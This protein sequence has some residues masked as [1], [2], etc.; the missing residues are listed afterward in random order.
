MRKDDS[1]PS[2]DPK[3]VPMRLACP[4]DSLRADAIVEPTAI[5]HPLVGD[6]PA[7]PSSG[8]VLN[9]RYVVECELGRGGMS[10]V[11]AARDIK[12]DRRVAIKFLAT[13]T[14]HDD[15]LRRFEQEARAAGSLNHPNVLTVYDIGT[16]EANPY[17][18]SELLE[19]G[20]LREHLEGAPFT[21]DES[22]DYAAQMADGLTAAHGKGIVHRDLKPENLFITGAGRLKILD[23]GI[24]KL[25]APERNSPELKSP[26]PTQTGAIL[27]TM[28]YMSPE[29][30]RGERADHRSDIFSGGAILYE[31][32]AGKRAFQASSSV[33]TAYAILHVKPPE[34]P[35]QVPTDL[36]SVVWRCLEKRPEDRFQSAR[37]LGLQLRKVSVAPSARRW[38]FAATAVVV[39]FIAFISVLS[40]GR[41]RGRSPPAA[42]NKARRSVAVLGFKNLSGRP[43]EA[44]FSTALSEMLS[45]ELA[46][47]E[48]LGTI[49]GESVSHMKTELALPDAETLAKETLFRIRKNLLADVVVLGS[50]V[51][52]GKEAGGQMRL[53]V[54]LQDAMA[55]ET[56]AV[57]SETGT[58]K[59][60]FEL[61]SRTGAKLRRKLGVGEVSSSEAAVVRAS[62]PSDVEA[63]RLYSEGLAKLRVFDANGA[64]DLLE[65]AVLVEPD[66]APSHSALSE[67]WSTLGYDA[68]ARDEAQKA[69][70]LSAALSRE[71]RLGVEG[72][73]RLTTGEWSKAIDV[74]KT[75]WDFFPDNVE[76]GVRLA[77]AQISAGKGKE[78][79]AT[80]EALSKLP[81][82]KGEDPRIDI[83][84]AEASESIS[85]F[86]REQE[87]AIRAVAKSELREAKLLAATARLRQ[88][89]A[90]LRLREPAKARAAYEE[91]QQIF[92]AAGNRADVARVSHN[93]GVLLLEQGDLVGA[94]ARFEQAL[95][96]FGD[97]GQKFLAA[98]ALVNIGGVLASEGDLEGAKRAHEQALAA[99]EKLG[100]KQGMA[101]SQASL[102]VVLLAEG[103]KT[104]AKR[105][106][107]ESLT[108]AREIGDR[109]AIS[110]ALLSLGTLLREEGDLAAARESYQQDLAIHREMGDQSGTAT[111][112]YNL[113]IILRDQGDLT[114]AHKSAEEA[115]AIK[116]QL[117]EEGNTA[118]CETSLASLALEEGRPSEAEALTRKAV[119]RFQRRQWPDG[120]AL[121]WAILAKSFLGQGEPD[122]AQ[123]AIARAAELAEKRR[124]P[125]LHFE[126]DIDSARVRA[127]MRNFAEAKKSLRETLAAAKK[128][129]SFR[130]H[131]EAR[132]ALGEIEMKSGH[133]G[134]A[135]AHLETVEKDATAHGFALIARRARAASK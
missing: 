22:I 30:V 84:E 100:D 93:I 27:G 42:A 66:H 23:F 9:E 76:Y 96:V 46:A 56:I 109:W 52:L 98:K 37:E 8:L 127:A 81:L 35:E 92:A 99:C 31:M 48:K 74:Y 62:L 88:G 53:D 61:V 77:R 108:T 73:Y 68:N 6:P 13:G 97:V 26:A 3:L 87:A 72:R 47:G 126:V 89:N 55:G 83:V 69:F 4:A 1:V 119:G 40:V 124:K 90:F 18:V 16:H 58:E 41:W 32:L 94:K 5:A 38:P 125:W 135:R 71:D 91:A 104:G 79:L 106:F 33:E 49:P 70:D 95:A 17:I 14:H 67:A 117:G 59:N 24:A 19:G 130:F 54:R 118:Y 75:L 80:V 78:A 121:A 132:L 15:E 86:N 65:K 113:G 2:A 105:R 50:Y 120:E 34:L 114:A 116:K 123:E 107:Q 112:L 103:N 63:A 110:N 43:E 60:L 29:Q 44:W 122:K 131:L 28:G 51:D 82:P 39:L 11:F 12:L 129:G 102:A 36:Q 115:L 45:T 134:A 85:D 21:V 20:T 64:R 111:A 128:D 57:I 7:G 101:E 133:S 25:V 10:R